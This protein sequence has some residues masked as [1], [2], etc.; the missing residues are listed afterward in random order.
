MAKGKSYMSKEEFASALKALEWDRLE[1]S[2]HLHINRQ[3][4]GKILTGQHGVSAPLALLLNYMIHFG[5]LPRS[6]WRYGK[7][8]FFRQ[9]GG[10]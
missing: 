2:I 7:P 3:H 1:A 10:D 9:H 8:L 5:K 4:I 6:G